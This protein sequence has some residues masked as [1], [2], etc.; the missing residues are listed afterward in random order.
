[1]NRTFLTLIALGGLLITGCKPTLDG[2]SEE[3]LTI[4][5]A[6]MKQ[7]M[8]EE[9]KAKFESAMAVV[10]FSEL[11]LG[12]A[13]QAAF[14]GEEFDAEAYADSMRLALDGMTADDIIERADEI[15]A[16]RDAEAKEEAK[17][18]LMGLLE[19]KAAAEQA[20]KGLALYKITDS[21]FYKRKSG[22]YYITEEPYIEMKVTNG[23]P[24][25]VS[26]AYFVGTLRTPGRS[27]PWLQ[28]DFNY[29]IPGGMEPGESDAWTLAPNSFSEWGSVEAPADAVLTI[30]TVQL[31][32][33]DGKPVLDS[34]AFSEA[35]AARMEEILQKYPDLKP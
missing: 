22:T 3:S 25:A 8:N 35:D 1:M 15:R 31:D 28:E 27:V 29:S 16:Q 34:R 32:G 13:M 26:R 18:E 23:T 24:H 10:F 5:I 7:S 12:K 20:R 19:K 33:P 6:K 21:R 9:E 11:D 4:S 17:T 30:E 14:K 2:T